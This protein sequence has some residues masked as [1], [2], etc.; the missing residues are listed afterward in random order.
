M[1]S[2]IRPSIRIRRALYKITLT[3]MVCTILSELIRVPA[4]KRR[5]HLRE[6]VAKSDNNRG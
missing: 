3:S 2:K 1:K 5:N 6:E 4:R